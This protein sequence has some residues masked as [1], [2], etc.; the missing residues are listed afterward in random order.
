MIM[1]LFLVSVLSFSLFAS[2]LDDLIE[3]ACKNSTIVKNTKAQIELSKLKKEETRKSGYGKI[4]LVGEYTHY[5]SPR[6]L[7]PLTP[8]SM[9]SGLPVT[10]TKDIYS[11]GVS[12]SVPLFTGYA[13][14]RQIEMDAI[15]KK[16]ADIKL[17]L[18]LEQL[19]YNIRSLY[20]SVLNTKDLLKAQVEYS[21]AL[22]ALS[23]QIKDEVRLGKKAEIDLIKAKA[24]LQASKT[25]EELFKSNINILLAALSS[26]TGKEVKDVED[27]EIEVTKPDY[28]LDNYLNGLENLYK[29]KVDS[30]AIQKAQKAIKKSEA[31]KYPMVN[32]NSYVGKNYGEDRGVNGWDDETLIQVGLSVKYTLVDFGTSDIATQKAK[33]SKMQAA[34]QKEQKILDTKKDINEAIQKIK[35]SY[36]S[37]LGNRAEYELSKKSEEIESV[38]YKS[39]VSTLNDLLLAKA[40]SE[41]AKVKVI[42]SR[43]DY[44]KSRYYLD[45]LMEK[46]SKNNNKIVEK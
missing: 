10:T 34:L 9:M 11:V 17:N 43:Y 39:G 35:Q 40:K 2:S 23:N 31:L 19:I 26:L 3:Y 29:I 16:I 18:T 45:Y 5:N 42:Q 1:K 33:I 14:T 28:D 20:I 4:N 15:S 25:K 24:D 41:F 6:T 21:K 22:K 8:S 13:T 38:R 37:Y 44:Q 7:A 27:I 30:L 32:L 46:G 12:Y 36:S